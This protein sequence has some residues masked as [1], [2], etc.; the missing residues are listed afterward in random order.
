ME[1]KGE[2]GYTRVELTHRNAFK[3]VG[4]VAKVSLI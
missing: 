3:S 1:L 2:Y 4:L